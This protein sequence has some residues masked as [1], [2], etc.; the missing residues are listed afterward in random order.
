MK[1]R[2]WGTVSRLHILSYGCLLSYCIT[3]GIAKCSTKDPKLIWI[4]EN[5]SYFF[6]I[7]LSTCIYSPGLFQN[8]ASMGGPLVGVF[9]LAG[10]CKKKS[11]WQRYECEQE[12]AYATS[13]QLYS[14]EMITWLNLVTRE[15]GRYSVVSSYVPSYNFRGALKKRKRKC[16]WFTACHC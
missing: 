6:P 15:A 12:S 16:F 1:E 11:E 5:G 7:F 14:S 13:A 8:R 4:K 2:A 9:H 3:W 10:S